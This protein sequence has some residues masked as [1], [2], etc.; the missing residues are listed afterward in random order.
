MFLFLLPLSLFFLPPLSTFSQAKPKAEDASYKCPAAVPKSSK[1]SVLVPQLQLA[2]TAQHEGIWC[3]ASR[4]ESA[5]AAGGNLIALAL[6]CT[7]CAAKQLEVSRGII[8]ED[9]VV[10]QVTKNIELIDLHGQR[11][12]LL[13][14]VL[15]SMF[16]NVAAARNMRTAQTGPNRL[17]GVAVDTV[18]FLGVEDGVIRGQPQPPH[19]LTPVHNTSLPA[20]LAGRVSQQLTVCERERLRVCANVSHQLHITMVTTVSREMGPSQGMAVL[21]ER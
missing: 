6:D 11:V 10:A 19:M 8:I 2:G 4:T 21:S 16:L 12:V 17:G 5:P 20:E 14:E 1:H 18:P 3:S 9:V 7:E 13:L 15:Q